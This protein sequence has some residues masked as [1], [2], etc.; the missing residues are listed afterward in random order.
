MQA[1]GVCVCAIHSNY[2]R[3]NLVTEHFN[4]SKP[5]TAT[6]RMRPKTTTTK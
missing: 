5:L 6:R 2:V 4:E 3:S 1:A